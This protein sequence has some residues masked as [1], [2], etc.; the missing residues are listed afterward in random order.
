MRLGEIADLVKSRLTIDDVVGR[1]VA[2]KPK[3]RHKVGLCPFHVERSP[4]F[5]V[6]PD[7]R[8][9]C[10]GCGA[11]GDIFDF[12][13]KLD[14]CDFATAVKDLAAA[15]GVSVNR[16]ETREQRKARQA[17]AAEERR[18]REDEER[19]AQVRRD[20]WMRASAAEIWHGSARDGRLLTYLQGRG[21][22]TDLVAHGWA[23]CAPDGVPL[24]LRF[25][26]ACPDFENKRTD[27][28]MVAAITR[29]AQ[30]GAGPLMAI[31]RTFLNRRLDGKRAFEPKKM[32][33]RTEGGVIRLTP[34]ARR[35]ILVEGIENGLTLMAAIARAGAVAGTS[36]ATGLSIDHIAGP[37]RGPFPFLHLPG[38]LLP[39]QV[40]ELIIGEDADN[41]DPFKADQLYARAAARYGHRTGVAVRRARA[42]EGLDFNDMLRRAA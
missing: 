29:C 35:M 22:D 37:G 40:R 31:H 8:F 38:L 32:L 23:D 10:F 12:V 21:I 42:A 17:R 30:D 7:G 28:A 13:Q 14:A 1:V 26:P 6:Y 11:H 36:V 4:S 2:L 9:H 39:P 3:A 20:A 18:A 5:T 41:K 27:P 25:H 15:C 16:T 33:G 34:P 19:A 24:S